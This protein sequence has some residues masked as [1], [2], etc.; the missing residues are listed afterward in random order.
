MNDWWRVFIGLDWVGCPICVVDTEDCIYSYQ[1]ARRYMKLSN[2]IN[3]LIYVQQSLLPFDC[4]GAIRWIGLPDNCVFEL[5]V[6]DAVKKIYV[7][8]HVGRNRRKEKN[9]LLKSMCKY[10]RFY[11]F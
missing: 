7:E 10:S 9:K 11:T 1:M 8:Y 6:K 3:K 2:M 4:S 5:K